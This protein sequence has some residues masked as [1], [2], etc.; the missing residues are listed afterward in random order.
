MPPIKILLQH[1]SKLVESAEYL[2]LK[3]ETGCPKATAFEGSDGHCNLC[4]ELVNKG[5][6]L[7]KLGLGF[8]GNH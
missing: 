4:F 6:E 5:K 2:L 3:E 7:V 8:T 1:E